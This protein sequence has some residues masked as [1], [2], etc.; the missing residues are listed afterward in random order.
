MFQEHSTEE[1]INIVLDEDKK[2]DKD[3]EGL[4][5]TIDEACNKY[6]KEQNLNAQKKEN[7]LEIE[8]ELINYEET[9]EKI[10]SMKKL[11]DEMCNDDKEVKSPES[12]MKSVVENETS[13][14]T[15][16]IN[17]DGTIT[18]SVEKKD[19]YTLED[20]RQKL[21][22]D[23]YN[24]KSYESNEIELIKILFENSKS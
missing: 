2:L 5:K 10:K 6:A 15:L 13:K 21:I 8:I 9:M 4:S 11:I 3:L 17:V 22:N 14:S 18:C 24:Q 16:E 1:I 7:K 19:N 12:L 23:L 20:L